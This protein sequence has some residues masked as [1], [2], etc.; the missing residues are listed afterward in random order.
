M[1]DVD[2]A[3]KTRWQTNHGIIADQPL[4]GRFGALMKSIRVA[5]D[6][7]TNPPLDGITR[8]WIEDMEAGR[9]F[10][11]FGPNYT[12]FTKYLAYLELNSEW[13]AYVGRARLW[14][15]N[16]HDGLQSGGGRM[17][18]A[19]WMAHDA[20][21]RAWPSAI[22]HSHPD[23]DAPVRKTVSALPK[24]PFVNPAEYRVDAV[25]TEARTQVRFNDSIRVDAWRRMFEDKLIRLMDFDERNELSHVAY[26]NSGAKHYPDFQNL[27]RDAY[28]QLI[29][30]L[31]QGY[32]SVPDDKDARAHFADTRIA[33]FVAKRLAEHRP[34]M[35][36]GWEYEGQTETT[37]SHALFG[38]IRE[39]I[40]AM[41]DFSVTHGIWLAKGRM[42]HF[43]KSLDTLNDL[44]RTPG[45]SSETLSAAA[46][47]AAQMDAA[48]KLQDAGVAYQAAGAVRDSKEV[49]AAK[50][51]LLYRNIPERLDALMKGNRWQD[52]NELSSIAMKRQAA[53]RDWPSFQSLRD[54][55][56]LKL[57]EELMR[58]Y[59]S[60]SIAKLDVFMN[61]AIER[62]FGSPPDE[63]KIFE[64]L[65][66]TIA[67]MPDLA[68]WNQIRPRSFPEHGAGPI[69]SHTPRGTRPHG[70]GR[71]PLK[72]PKV[73]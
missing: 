47:G 66:E 16:V 54:Q 50:Q 17:S 5:L 14:Q 58:G 28:F 11:D 7:P 51:T 38:I 63:A 71:P 67:T 26:S 35:M 20:S 19:Q 72:P 61:Q 23:D 56:Y 30:D 21:W 41:P 15:K 31:M 8:G 40:I 12:K 39:N 4:D 1:P 49:N 18:K 24:E 37:P 68:E 13:Q 44:I 42:G 29:H 27:R 46:E 2:A 59:E 70:V 60:A 33:D 64:T 22:P 48:K 53:T 6:A 36:R 65:K 32:E 25:R 43:G 52:A 73:R 62:R 69:E 55:G 10:P 3:A 45:L 9:I 34:L 57:T